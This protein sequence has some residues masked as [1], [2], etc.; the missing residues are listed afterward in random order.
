MESYIQLWSPQNRKGHGHVG[1]GPE[2]GHQNDQRAGILHL[3]G[4]NEGVGTVQPGEEKTADRPYCRLP[5]TGGG[6]YK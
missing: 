5:V 4:K 2:E 1:A 6:W 3:R